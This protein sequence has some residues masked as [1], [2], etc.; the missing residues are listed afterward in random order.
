MCMASESVEGKENS[1]LTALERPRLVEYTNV[2][3]RKFRRR[4]QLESSSDGPATTS[5]AE[6]ST[7]VASATAEPTVPGSRAKSLICDDENVLRQA[8]QEA[9]VAKDGNHSKPPEEKPSQPLASVSEV[10]SG[11]ENVRLIGGNKDGSV[12]A[13]KGDEK[14]LLP[15][16]QETSSGLQPNGEQGTLSD[17][18]H[19]Q[20]KSSGGDHASQQLQDPNRQE[21]VPDDR[22]ELPLSRG[23]KTLSERQPLPDVGEE[24]PSRSSQE[25]S[26]NGRE[27]P[28][29]TTGPQEVTSNHEDLEHPEHPEH[30]E[31]SDLQAEKCNI[32]TR[33]L[34]Q[35]GREE[36]QRSADGVSHLSASDRQVNDGAGAAL[37]NGKP[38]VA[39]VEDRIRINLSESTSRDDIIGVKRKLE[40]ELVQVRSLV[41]KL[42]AKELRS[43]AYNTSNT[44]NNP[45][46]VGGVSSLGAYNQPHLMRVHSDLGSVAGRAQLMRVN[47]EVGSVGRQESRPF[48]HLTVSVGNNHG[49]GEFVEKEKRTPKANQY[50]RNSEF[51]LGKDRLPPENKRVKPNGTG[52][53]HGG[54]S[55]YEFGFGIGFDKNK[56][57]VFRNCNNLLQRLMKH[58]HGWVF[59]EPVDAQKLCIPDYHDIIKHPMDFGTIK[60]R[61]SQNWYKSPREFAEDVRL[62]FRNAMTYNPQGQDVH[63]MAEELSKIFEEKWTT[64]EKEYFPYQMY[65]DGGLPIPTPRRV[66]PPLLTPVFSPVPAPARSAPPAR[67]LDRSESMTMAVDSKLK[68]NFPP[69]RTPVPKKPKAKDPNK[70]DMTYEEKQKLSTNLQS[71]PVEKLDAIV[72]IIKK[73]NTTLS[74]H[75]DEIEVDIDS[76]DAETLWELD[77]FVTNYK[78]SLSKNKRKAEL[79]LKAA[80]TVPIMNTAL[81]SSNAQKEGRIGENTDPLPVQVEKQGDNVS[82]SSSS[83]SSSSDSGSSSSDS[84]SDSSSA[85][86]SDAGRSPKS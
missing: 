32:H 6:P 52:K 26:T 67:T 20:E 80:Q 77:R 71:L 31:R 84:D 36:Q 50:Y 23:N 64:I 40:G 53:K 29:P 22:E 37:M 86:G 68:P 25:R 61:L 85:Y 82:V 43:T 73:R 33:Q 39:R 41:R 62:V 18:Q 74:Q 35:N 42:E 60:T 47:S 8:L 27:V 21:Q 56:E 76:V 69:S 65:Y 17:G 44:N 16:G 34:S 75:D 58:K 49:I 4:A 14:R 7:A 48:R 66:P 46:Y 81:A 57:K 12:D 78:K 54:E 70:R 9:L 72:Q 83:S 3:T 10:V 15:D 1:V 11:S 45:S 38:L 59:N 51:L 2:Y 19:E 30:P 13:L 5:T 63:T 24:L 55:E 79:A 28:Q